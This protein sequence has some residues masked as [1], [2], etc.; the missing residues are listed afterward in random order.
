MWPV[1][2]DG[3]DSPRLFTEEFPFPDG[4]AHFY[5]VEWCEPCEEASE[6]YFHH[7]NNGHLLEHFEQ[8]AM[9]YRSKGLKR[10]TPTN[11]VEVSP[12]LARQQGMETGSVV[13]LRSLYGEAT[14]PVV[15]TDRVKGDQL[16]MPLNSVEQ[17][18][19]RLTGLKVDR[20]TH[21]PAYKEASVHI[22][23]LPEKQ[24]D[25]LP[26]EN[27]RHGTPAPQSGV[28]VERKWKRADYQ[29]FGSRNEE[30]LVQITTSRV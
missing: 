24:A 20:A 30:K 26:A 15:V 17:P 2:K 16:Y 4:K 11:F 12:E 9:T 29:L 27:F 3:T 7:L 8:G 18:V 23:V 5:P 22:T 28:K 6:E 19:N 21:A 13:K 1:A 14:V 25:P 10:M